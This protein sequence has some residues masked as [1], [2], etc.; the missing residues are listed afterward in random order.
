[1]VNGKNGEWKTIRS[2]RESD[3]GGAT[4]SR[5]DDGGD[6]TAGGGGDRPAS[7][8]QDAV[9]AQESPARERRRAVGRGDSERRRGSAF[10]RKGSGADRDSGPRDRMSLRIAGH[11]WGRGVRHRLLPVLA[12]RA[13]VAVAVGGILR[14][15]LAGGFIAGGAAR[16]GLRCR[17]RGYR[18]AIAPWMT[19]P[20][21]QQHHCGPRTEA[22]MIAVMR[23][24]R[25]M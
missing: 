3:V 16:A 13:G 24:L 23:S 21:L 20:M 17:C 4:P 6:I 22:E 5:C 1:M 12:A 9:G 2:L 10:Q 15:G 8:A 19:A 14:G 7:A 18:K 11:E 25:T